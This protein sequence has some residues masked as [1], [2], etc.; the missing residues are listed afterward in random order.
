SIAGGTSAADIEKQF[1]TL[2]DGSTVVFGE[3]TFAMNDTI[4]IAANNVTVIGAGMG[5]TIFDFSGQKGGDGEGFFAQSVQNLT[6]RNFTVKD[7]LGNAV[8]VLGATGV[9]FDHLETT[10]TSE[11]AASHGGYGL[12]PVLSK[13][14]VI[15]NC[16]ASGASDSG[17]YLGQSDHA[18]IHDNEVHDNVAG[19]EVE[20]TWFTDVHDNYAH[21]NTGGI[22]VFALPGL[23]QMGTH[24]IRVFKNRIENNNTPSFAAPGNT[25]GLVPRGTGFLVMAATNVELFG[26]TLTGNETGNSAIISYY[27]TQIAISDQTY[28]PLPNNVSIHDNTFTGGGD[29]PDLTKQFGLL[30]ASAQSAFPGNVVPSLMWDGIEDPQ[31]ASNICYAND[32]DA[33]YV[34]LH[35]DQVDPQNPNLPAVMSVEAPPAGSCAPLAVVTFAGSDQ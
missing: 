12:Y 18:V 34:D 26:N 22:L 19:I 1:A 17:I 28:D 4:I 15:E 14:V 23:Q 33:K 11:D 31:T 8:K 16:V 30:L 29:I 13:N 10:W 32:G 9:R 21:D 6:L 5:K 20:N 24:D 35:L 2:T 7:T 25:V 27:A 3:G